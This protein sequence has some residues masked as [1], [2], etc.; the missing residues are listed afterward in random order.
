M[1]KRPASLG[2]GLLFLSLVGCDT[3]P[4]PAELEVRAIEALRTEL[5]AL[6]ERY[7]ATHGVYAAH[8]RDLTG[9][10]DTLASG[11]RIILRGGTADGWG[12]TSSHPAVPGAACA[13][14]V[15]NPGVRIGL[16]GGVAPREPGFVSCIRPFAQ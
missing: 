15:G 11:I 10:V 7:R 8:M 13:V 2:I 3:R 1:L 16:V 5:P 4:S 12:A 9:G 14:F 6:Q